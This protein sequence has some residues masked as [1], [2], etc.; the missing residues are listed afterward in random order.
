MDPALACPRN[1]L[2]SGGDIFTMEGIKPRYVEAL[3]EREGR[4]VYVGSERQARGLA[5]AEP[6]FVDLNGATLLPGLIDAHGHFIVASHTVLNANLT[7]ARSIAEV[8]DRLRTHA[9]SLPPGEWIEGMGYRVEQLAERRHPTRAELDQVSAV[10]PVFVQDG[11]GHEGSIN[12][13]L[14]RQMGWS[15]STDPDEQMVFAV[16]QARPPRSPQRIREGVQRALALWTMNGQTTATEQGLGLGAHDLDVVERLQREQLLPIDLVLYAKHDWRER[17]GQR[18]PDPGRYNRRVRWAG[19]KVWLDGHTSQ[20]KGSSRMDLDTLFKILQR[21]QLDPRWPGARQLG[22]HAVGD[23]A[24]DTLLQAVDQLVR[25]LGLTDHRIVLHHGVVLRPDQIQELQ[26]LRVIVSF[27]AAGLYPM[28]DAL[29]R[30]L[31][32]ERQGWLGPIGSVQRSGRPFTL[33]HDVPAGVSPSLIDALW[34]AV[35]RTTRSGAVVQ[36][37]ERITPYAGLQ[38]LTS[39]AAYQLFEEKQKGSLEVGKLADLVVLDANPLKVDPM[40]IRQ[41]KV[42]ATIKQGRE[43]YRSPHW[44]NSAARTGQSVANHDQAAIPKAGAQ[45]RPAEKCR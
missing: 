6:R 9:Q 33:H 5:D 18:L 15:S 3:L 40:A 10:R 17:V 35:T 23:Q 20:Q 7:G 26:R 1:T 32:P 2:Y 4:I 39:H 43:V 24:A 27:T 11:S 25:S 31:G 38:A 19:V 16:M 45:Q 36:P 8:I 42:L 22:A 37:D 21:L 34:S 29:A 41:I 44:I 30:A 28:G 14:H 12:S 13:V